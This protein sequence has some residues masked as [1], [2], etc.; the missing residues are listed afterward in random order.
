MSVRIAVDAMGGDHAPAVTVEGAVQAVRHDA[1]LQVLLVGPEAD[2]RAELARHDGADQLPIHVVHAPE[3]IGMHESP[4]AAV[5]Q[6]RQSSIHIGI[7]AHKAGKADAFLS[8]GN[9]GAIMAA[10]LFMLGRLPGVSRPSVIGF[11]PTVESYCIVLD[12]GT[13]VDC[14]PE[15]LVE[16]ARMGQVYAQRVMNRETPRVGLLNIGEEESKGDELTKATYRLLKDEAR[17][18][19]VGNI[20]GRDIMMGSA[21]VVVCDGFTGNALLKF[22]ESV[23]SVLPIML[24]KTMGQLGLVAEQQQLVGRVFHEVKKPFD[25]EEFGGAPLLG[26]QGHVLIGHGGSSARAIRNLIHSAAAVARQDLA[27][28]IAASFAA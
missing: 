2:V 25:Y 24:K 18:N 20:E 17:I 1:D 3:V 13:N 21:D 26:V 12:V 14:K 10:S 4:V 9:T 11:F 15:H 19:F 16:F 7:G 5:K 27:G 28:S 22:G 6:K 8:A 23:A